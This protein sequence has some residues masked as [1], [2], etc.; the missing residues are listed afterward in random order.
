VAHHSVRYQLGPTAGNGRGQL[1]GRVQARHSG[2]RGASVGSRKR[3]FF[4]RRRRVLASGDRRRACDGALKPLG[5][6]AGQRRQ[7]RLVGNAS[8]RAN[9]GDRFSFRGNAHA[10]RVKPIVIL[11][12]TPERS[13]RAPHGR[14]TRPGSRANRGMK[15]LSEGLSGS[16][17]ASGYPG[18]G[19]SLGDRRRVGRFRRWASSSC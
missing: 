1:S 7:R 8:C 2:P 5:L 16:G 10:V 6:V 14:S 15:T 9:A 12:P 3:R 18:Q 17:L 11:G 13:P 19:P 4:A